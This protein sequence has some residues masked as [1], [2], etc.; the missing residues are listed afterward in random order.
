[1][2]RACDTPSSITL[3][4]FTYIP[5]EGVIPVKLIWNNIVP[6]VTGLIPFQSNWCGSRL[7]SSEIW[8]LARNTLLK[9]HLQN[10][11]DDMELEALISLCWNKISN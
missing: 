11:N 5:R 1:M 9:F 4:Q 10:E 3:S 8:G 7:D 6:R 2:G